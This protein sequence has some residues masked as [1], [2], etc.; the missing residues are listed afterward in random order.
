MIKIDGVMT[1]REPMAR[2]TSF[3]LGGP[4]DLYVAPSRAPDVTTV[5]R[6]CEKAGVPCFLLGG[7]TN[8]L[9]ADKGVRGVVLDLSGLSGMSADG[10]RITVLA[11]SPV[12]E[13][14][15]FALSCGLTGL[16]F[17]YALPG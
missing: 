8:I 16:E 6:A 5:T 10:G 13:L 15:E 9:V 11:G 17:A 4:A 3:R 12:S 1:R 7:G 2:H 14:S